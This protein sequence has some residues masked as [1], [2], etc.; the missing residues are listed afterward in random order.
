MTEKHEQPGCQAHP[1]VRTASEN[2]TN[3]AATTAKADDPLG[4]FNK[5]MSHCLE[6]ART[7][8][9]HGHPIVGIMCEF[10]PR[11]LIMAAGAVPVCLCGGSAETIPAAERDLP[12]NLCPLIKSTYGYHVLKSNPFLEM[13]DLVVAE[14]T[15][16]GKKKM[17]E[18]MGASRPMHVLQLPHHVELEESRR[19]WEKELHRLKGELE[20]RFEVV[21]TPDLVRKSIAV[22]NRERSYRR[23]LAELMQ[24]DNP[25]ITGRQ[26]VSM[27]CGICGIKGGFRQYERVLEWAATH[28][29]NDY[30]QRTRVLLTGVP[31]AFG[32]ERVIDII[33]Q[34]GGLVVCME[35]CTGVKPVLDDVPE[36]APD[37]IAALADKY[38]HLPCS[39]MT[40]N[41]R[42]K[43]V[44]RELVRQYRPHCVIDLIWQAC[45]T[46]DVEACSVRRF[47]EE[48]LHLP[49]LRI[50]TDYSPG[51][52]ARI[53]VRVEAL[54][55]MARG[56][57]GKAG[58]SA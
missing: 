6:Y 32:A 3:S 21:I 15:C 51:D 19:L 24:A 49:Y 16:D 1:C 43:E 11:E 22:M 45:L 41:H 39:V 28:S 42:R 58:C 36:D 38:F 31:T 35:N 10:T 34:Q 27:R 44:L 48:E 4:W 13:A 18:L 17:F 56:R 8:K 29:E 52:S 5:I 53:A 57:G 55:E 2:C 46:Y 12:A 25:P 47:V 23:R 26:L 54:F 30:S 40:P 37:P 50:E 7:A 20:R 33:E 9:E 14:T